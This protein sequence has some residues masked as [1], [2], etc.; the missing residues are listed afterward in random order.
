VREMNK[1]D[2]DIHD[3][4]GKLV[5]VWDPKWR[6]YISADRIREDEEKYGEMFK[7]FRKRN[8]AKS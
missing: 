6:F 4:L 3:E 8:Q 7:M 5:F 2:Q 1:Q